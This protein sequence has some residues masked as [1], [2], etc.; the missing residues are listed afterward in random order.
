MVSLIFVRT[1]QQN[2]WKFVL[3]LIFPTSYK[4]LTYDDTILST[5]I[6][7]NEFEMF[8]YLLKYQSKDFS[9]SS[10]LLSPFLLLLVLL[11]APPIFLKWMNCHVCPCTELTMLGC[12]PVWMSPVPG[13]TAT[14]SQTKYLGEEVAVFQNK[15]DTFPPCDWRS[16][17]GA[18]GALA[19]YRGAA[20][21]PSL[22]FA[23]MSADSGF[24]LISD[25]GPVGDTCLQMDLM[26]VPYTL[27]WLPASSGS[28]DKGSSL[29]WV[30]AC[31]EVSRLPLAGLPSSH[32]ALTQV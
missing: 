20:A 12:L 5:S 27:R 6:Q 28:E 17:G 10:P 4:C 24:G 21:P 31:L 19:W 2:R 13:L 32:A 30:L 7:H 23:L 3:L 29:V 16:N 22:G 25:S 8:Q 1:K 14:R 15:Q 11:S 26:R 18:H 9:F